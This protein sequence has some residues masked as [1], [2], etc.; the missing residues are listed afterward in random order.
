MRAHVSRSGRR[1]GLTLVEVCLVLALLVVIVAVAIPAMGGAFARASLRGGCDTLRAAWSKARMAA[2]QKGQTYAFRCQPR[3]SH[4]QIIGLDQIGSPESDN[5]QP[6]DSEAE[7]PPEDMLRLARTQLP[8]GV[9]FAKTDVVNSTQ[10]ASTAGGGGGGAL[11]P[12]FFFCSCRASIR[13]V[14]GFFK[15]GRK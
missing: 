5:Q 6:T 13:G 15:E 7:R 12:A 14:A 3:G 2:I 11:V 8:D 1:R 4:F 10:L 9:I